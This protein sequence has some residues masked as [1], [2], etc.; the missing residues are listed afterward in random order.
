MRN[1]HTHQVI[2]T[3]HQRWIR[4]HHRRLQSS[5]PPHQ[6]NHRSCSKSTHWPSHYKPTLLTTNDAPHIVTILLGW[7][8]HTF[9]PGGIPSTTLRVCI[10][11][12]GLWDNLTARDFGLKEN[13]EDSHPPQLYKLTVVDT[14]DTRTISQQLHTHSAEAKARNRRRKHANIL[15]NQLGREQAEIIINRQPLTFQN[16]RM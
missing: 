9:A 1:I 16:L 10:S 11:E 15:R 14:S 8:S 3:R 5:L 12:K 6:A 13:D 4:H 7:P 2:S